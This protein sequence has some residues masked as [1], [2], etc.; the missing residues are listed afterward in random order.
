MDTAD[1]EVKATL[2]RLG[3]GRRVLLTEGECE[4]WA[5]Q[6]DDQGNQLSRRTVLVNTASFNTSP[7]PSVSSAQYKLILVSQ[8]D[9]GSDG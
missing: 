5:A 3:A 9:Q 1:G 6:V 4:A 8:K 2:P 7:R